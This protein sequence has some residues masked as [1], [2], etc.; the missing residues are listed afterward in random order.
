[1]NPVFLYEV[2]LTVAFSRKELTGK[3]EGL[4]LVLYDIGAVPMRVL[5][6]DM[7]GMGS[8]S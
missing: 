7:S 5:T 6:W 8:L 1:M 3:P 2:G 4:Q